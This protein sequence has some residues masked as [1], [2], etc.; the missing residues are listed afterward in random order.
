MVTG[1]QNRYVAG[2]GFSEN[3]STPV[4]FSIGVSAPGSGY[5]DNLGFMSTSQLNEFLDDIFVK[6]ATAS[7]Y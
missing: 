6:L 4:I 5:Q 2:P 7:Y 3:I 1:V